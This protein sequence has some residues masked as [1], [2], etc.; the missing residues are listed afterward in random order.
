MSA[1]TPSA[2]QLSRA[3]IHRALGEPLRLAIVDALAL[4]DMTPSEV[5]HQLGV[6]SNLLAHHL[7]ALEQAGLIARTRSQGDGRRRY[8]SLRPEAFANA[9]VDIATTSA[10]R[11][12]EAERVVFVCTKN[13]AR[14][15]LAMALWEQ[16]GSRVP[17]TSAGTHPAD[18][19]HP[20]AVA[21]GQQAGLTTHHR[22]QP[23][24][25]L[26]QPGDL[27]VTVCDQA[28][29][30][31]P[32]DLHWSIPDPVRDGRPEAFART[33]DILRERTSHLARHIEPRQR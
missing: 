18:T 19:V 11:P 12:I 10:P 23:L 16:A 6:P 8:L 28:H 24:D 27:L 5:E 15:P 4:S 26:R 3:S 17:S 32:G 2:G 20:L 1:S 29:E 25:E 9:G 31:A 33:V 13:S 22:P 21:A 30:E 7:D 14:S